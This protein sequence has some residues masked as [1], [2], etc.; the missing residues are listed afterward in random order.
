MQSPQKRSQWF[1]IT[2]MYTQRHNAE[3]TRHSQVA[4]IASTVQTG[5]V[6]L[7]KSRMNTILKFHE[8]TLSNILRIFCLTRFLYFIDIHIIVII[9]GIGA[10]ILWSRNRSYL[11]LLVQLVSSFHTLTIQLSLNV[12]YKFDRRHR[13]STYNGYFRH[14]SLYCDKK[15]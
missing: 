8:F 12:K 11:V 14:R 6:K 2:P 9:F 3:Y 13:K 5:L 4:K 7:I 15:L 1:Q 10:H